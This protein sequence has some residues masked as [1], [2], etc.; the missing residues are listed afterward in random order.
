MVLRSGQLNRDFQRSQAAVHQERRYQ[1][2]P[3]SDR[4]CWDS[5]WSRAEDGQTRAGRQISDALVQTDVTA[6]LH[7]DLPGAEAPHHQGLRLMVR[8]ALMGAPWSLH[9][10]CCVCHADGTVGHSSSSRTG[11]L[12]SLAWNAH[13]YL[14][15]GDQCLPPAAWQV[16]PRLVLSP[17]RGPTSTSGASPLVPSVAS[18]AWGCEAFP[19][20]PPPLQ[21][22]SLSPSS[23]RCLKE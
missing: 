5:P 7:C 12:H 21:D 13:S 8:S 3:D 17:P 9:P 2:G 4:R 20:S 16:S 6:S 1:R 14:C 19:Y 18:S 15:R 10:P 23:L 22:G 11:L